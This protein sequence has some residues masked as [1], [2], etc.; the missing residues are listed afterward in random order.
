MSRW[1]FPVAIAL[2]LLAASLVPQG[3]ATA[4]SVGRLPT[5][6]G[7]AVAAWDAGS[8]FIFGGCLSTGC[9]APATDEI[10]RYDPASQEV[11]LAGRLPD[12]RHGHALALD[13][14]TGDAYVIGG[15]APARG[16]L[17]EVVRYNVRLGGS[18]SVVGHMRVATGLSAAAWA[19]GAAW[20][21]GGELSPSAIVRVD[22]PG[23]ATTLP[24]ALEP[25][26][27]AATAVAALGKIY[28]IGGRVKP[29]N[30]LLGEIAEFD[31]ATGSIRT[32][33]TFA[34]A[35][36]GATAIWDGEAIY[37]YGGDLADTSKASTVLRYAPGAAG[38]E[39]VGQLL[40]AR[41]SAA[42]ASDGSV[43]YLFGGGAAGPVVLD[44][45]A[46][47]ETRPPAA[48]PGFDLLGALPSAR[49][50]TS[51]VWTGA[52]AFVFGGQDANGSPLSEILRVDP[53]TGAS[54]LAGQL[55]TPRDGTSA[56]WTGS[57]AYVFGGIR[58]GTRTTEI[59]RFDPLTGSAG[60]VGALPSA[61]DA[62]SAIWDGRDLPGMGCAGG[63]AYVFGGNSGGGLLTDV[64][65][66]NPATGETSTLS[67]MFSV[68]P[69]GSG[70]AWDGENAFLFGGALGSTV[71]RW[72]PLL[73]DPATAAGTIPAS[74]SHAAA[75][76]AGQGA[77]AIGSSPIRYDVLN[78]TA[79][80]E[81][82][83]LGDRDGASAVWTGSSVLVFGGGTIEVVRYTPASIGSC[84]A[85]IGSR[86]PEGRDIAS[87]VW[88]GSAAYLMGGRMRATPS[89]DA[90]GF[91]SDGAIHRFDPVSGLWRVPYALPQPVY[92][93]P[94]VWTGNVAYVFGGQI[95]TNGHVVV[96]DIVRVDPAA[97][98]A[99]TLA[100]LPSG[101]ASAGAA[102]DGTFAWVF[103]GVGP[104]S[105]DYLD[106][107]VRFDPATH[108]VLTIATRLPDAHK[109]NPE[110]AHVGG[111]I[112]LFGGN[113]QGGV[114]DRISA[115]YPGNG[116]LL[117]TGARFGRPTT[118][119][120]AIVDGDRVLLVSS[121]GR[122]D[123]FNAT[124]WGLVTGVET[125]P[126]PAGAWHAVAGGQPFFSLG[127]SRSLGVQRL[128]TK[129][130]CFGAGGVDA[131]ASIEIVGPMQ[132]TVNASAAYDAIGRD[133]AG[134]EV[135]LA[136]VWSSSCGAIDATTGLFR[137]PTTTQACQIHADAQGVRGSA[138]VSIVAAALDRI[139]VEGNKTVM[140][141]SS[142]RYTARG[143]DAYGNDVA[144]HAL[145]WAADCGSISANGT[146]ASPPNA[147]NCTVSATQAGVVG[148]LAVEVLPL[149]PDAPQNLT[150]IAD[151][152]A[153]GVVRVSWEAP[154]D[155]GGEA[156][157]SYRLR[158]TAQD[159]SADDFLVSGKTLELSDR[160]LP[161]GTY[162][163]AV[164]A[165]NRGGEGPA[166]ANVTVRVGPRERTLY[167]QT[168]HVG[169]NL[170]ADGADFD[171][172]RVQGRP[173]GGG[174]YEVILTVEGQER[175]PIAILTGGA[176]IPAFDTRQIVPPVGPVEEEVEG[177]T[178]RV[179]ID[180]RDDPSRSVCLIA[181]E[182][183]C[184]QHAPSDPNDA[185]TASEENAWMAL[186]V[187]LRLDAGAAS[188]D[189]TLVV[190]F[191]GQAGGSV[192]G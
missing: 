2:A 143:E 107:I 85:P 33:A 93:A 128:S 179:T 79:W 20:V 173:V 152:R 130:L 35:R 31:P 92:H 78:Q 176:P 22:P 72:D 42:A 28:V 27:D 153:R 64:V 71:W 102:W 191:V 135:P 32:V 74:P 21:F 164:A 163:Y 171:L 118:G 45:I 68:S 8:A 81:E 145:S 138:N 70:A 37:V 5:A 160:D 148:S 77:V 6:R 80:S 175:P 41:A 168:L 108:N 65:R 17:D 124:S 100:H 140:V 29:S 185:W 188:Q 18:P 172:V 98:T 149:A 141:S 165:T 181:V 86:L 10:L 170:T 156:P 3:A 111:V 16:Y 91:R 94:S 120:G 47:H 61:R 23:N 121:D 90:T 12:A 137:A 1:G 15:Y 187:R 11:S 113:G 150:A 19:E 24:R 131:L 87:A 134:R 189:Q 96:S 133:A 57:S 177:A 169:G 139:I 114:Q 84:R 52:A 186:L 126:A 167:D 9:G 157:G 39:V 110:A 161:Y 112:Y 49:R 117:D 182:G 89:S 97:G 63:C 66:F 36:S 59:V 13:D 34:P 151:L 125:L 122:I 51:A 88:T 146:L 67:G 30:V 183:G 147:T 155:D 62:T 123:A 116:T 38:V 40:P 144:L 58:T 53:R 46:R 83:A 99:A 119:L 55:P 7:L 159:G 190:P 101:R 75:V 44:A 56:I 174:S 50:H 142:S 104:S 26:R 106:E 76:W 178:L 14:A 105:G 82:A 136:P 129:I 127:G 166:S 180:Q 158:R 109:L 43:T 60:A 54:T 115:F 95:A 69:A 4:L 48:T 154:V 132:V 73:R 184:V 162:T 192:V 25:P 103:G